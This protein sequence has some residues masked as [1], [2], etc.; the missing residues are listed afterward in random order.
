MG[1]AEAWRLET[2]GKGYRY[3]LCL[4]CSDEEKENEM[5]GEERS[6]LKGA[7]KFPDHV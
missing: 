4:R 2:G 5:A 1:K 6:Q 3:C 7:R